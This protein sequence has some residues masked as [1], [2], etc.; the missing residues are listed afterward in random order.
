[1]AVDK[2][3]RQ[4]PKGITWLSKKR[5]YM[6][7]F[8]YQ[9][10]SYTIYDKS[11]K[12]VKEK[13]ADKRYEVQHGLSGKV[14]K[15]TLNMWYEIWLQDYKRNAVKDTTFQT[16]QAL[17]ENH[18]RNTLGRQHLTQIKPLHIQKFY[19][20][21]IEQGYA[22][23]SLQTLHALLNNLLEIAVSN[24]LLTKNPS[25]NTIR[26]MAQGRE[27]RVLSI[28]EQ[29]RLLA[30]VK[31]EKWRF[32]EPVVVTM[33]GTGMRVGEL[34][35]L[36]WEDVDFEKNTISI[37]RTL[38]YLKKKETGKYGFEEQ[39][40]KTKY[41]KRTIPLYPQV[42]SALHKQKQKQNQIA[43]KESGNWQPYT[44]LETL[45]FTGRKGQPQQT[46]S[47]QN[48]LNR[49]REAINE[50][51]LANARLENR[52]P[53]LMEHIHPHTLRHSFATRCFEADISPK[54][55]QMLLGHANIQ[56][57]LDLYTHVSEAKKLQDMQKLNFLF[58][59]GI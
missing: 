13:L 12:M 2:N 38:V 27:R 49:I 47:I 1:M 59:D 45:V 41:S 24:D 26:P 19:N 18:L 53:M 55:V 6:A 29:T 46:T 48:M 36:K 40:P 34:L 21:F 56:I 20:D 8:T 44:G 52:I 10:I 37:N 7:R 42:A 54:T 32:F 25:K 39:T 58:T 3:G 4:L 51:E 57:T 17:Y 23:T 43:G 5:L 9:G 31:Q 35:G 11:L 15:I 50:E 14:D 33:L 30:Y 22:A 16:Y 28:A